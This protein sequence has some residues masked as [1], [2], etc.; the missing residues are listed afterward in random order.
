ME[1]IIDALLFFNK[2]FVG[3]DTV[4][5]EEEKF[6]NLESIRELVIKEFS[7]Y[8][9][10]ELVSTLDELDSIIVADIKQKFE[11][12]RDRSEIFRWN[13]FSLITL[14]RSM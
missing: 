2:T 12:V 1:T 6:E 10:N 5:D 13:S 14:K 11:E 8:N 4:M 7:V 3:E 9:W